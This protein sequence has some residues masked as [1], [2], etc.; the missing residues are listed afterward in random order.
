MKQKFALLSLAPT[1]VFG[2]AGCTASPPLIKPDGRSGWVT[3]IYSVQRLITDTPKCLKGLPPEQLST[4]NFV[5][6][7]I[8]HYRSY[9]HVSAIVPPG[10]NLALH[11]KVEVSPADCKDGKIPVIQQI[12]S[13]HR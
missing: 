3:D 12:L 4:G 7:R 1:L 9:R 8:S 2:L 5:E 13:K 10:L 11:D 6:V